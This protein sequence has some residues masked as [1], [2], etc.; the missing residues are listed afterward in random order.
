MTLWLDALSALTSHSWTALLV[1]A[2]SLWAVF[3]MRGI[4]LWLFG[5]ALR[6]DE[7]LALSAGAWLLPIFLFSVLGFGAALIFN[8]FIGELIC[9]ALALIAS[10]FFLRLRAEIPFFVFIV[11]F[12]ISAL[13]R[14]AFI[15]DLTLPSYFDS[16]EHY[17]LIL[18]LE[19][20]LNSGDWVNEL[21]SVNYHLGFHVI[22]VFLARVLHTNIIDLMLVFGQV[23]LALLPFP[24]Y[25]IV[26]RITNSSASALLAGAVVG[27]GFH[28]PAHLMNWGKY[29]ALLGFALFLFVFG[30]GFILTQPQKFLRRP[31]AWILVI[32]ALLCAGLIHTRILILAALTAPALLLAQFA[33]RRW[34]SFFILSAALGIL[35]V[36]IQINSALNV[37]ITSYLRNDLW[38]LLLVLP[39]AG[40]AAWHF[41]KPTFFLLA[42]LTLSL[43]C[44]FIPISLPGFG[45][46]TM[47]DRPFAQMFAAL[48]LATIS[49]LGLT[50]LTYL[51]ARLT[52]DL[53]LIQRFIPI[54]IPGLF[55]LNTALNYSF[56]PSAC[57]RFAT[58]DDLAA[59]TWLDENTPADAE[60]WIAS[61]SLLV[62][63]LEPPG[64]PIAVDAGIWIQPFTDRRFRFAPSEYAFANETSHADLCEHDSSYVYVGGMPQSFDA[65]QLDSQPQWYLPVFILPEA[66]V[67]Q[68]LC[69][70]K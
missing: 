13:L 70:A 37:F 22:I 27:F 1:F 48:P 20:S 5:E 9:L 4:L 15:S 30:F 47:L 64:A 6:E 51:A 60:V 41:P 55:L 3:V 40:V 17:R 38:A 31:A 59:F 67:Y 63:S 52:P 7:R 8:P 36:F 62:T 54:L 11:L 43:A 26:K 10:V 23:T 24:L 56:H 44:V 14:F 12:F 32:L 34:V 25:F 35:L 2:V 19:D 45:V 58:R 57:C 29:P 42:W 49:G 39:L 18:L 28:M 61:A 65:A 50:A 53:N 66:R 21:G 46:Q 16:A 68:I 33:S 69:A